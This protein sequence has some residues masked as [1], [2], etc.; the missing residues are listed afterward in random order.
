[1]KI[2]AWC[3]DPPARRDRDQPRMRRDIHPSSIA[4]IAAAIA[5]YPGGIA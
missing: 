3:A 2:S 1:M 5:A 4:D